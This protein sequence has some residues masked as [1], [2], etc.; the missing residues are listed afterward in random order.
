METYVCVIYT[1]GD[2]GIISEVVKC[3]LQKNRQ[4]RITKVL[5]RE[6]EVKGQKN[7]SKIQMWKRD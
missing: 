2:R 4:R 7:I 5:R 1:T 3:M 6:D